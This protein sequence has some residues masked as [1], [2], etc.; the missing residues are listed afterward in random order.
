MKFGKFVQACAGAAM[1]MTL[2]AKSSS[3]EAEPPIDGLIVRLKVDTRQQALALRENATV[4]GTSERAAL[5]VQRDTNLR[6]RLE[7]LLSRAGAASIDATIA[8]P[9]GRA[10]HLLR[11]SAPLDRAAAEAL[12]ETLKKQPEIESVELNSVEPRLDAVVSRNQSARFGS[13]L[14]SDPLYLSQQWMQS[15]GIRARGLPDLPS[16][17][18][19]STGSPTGGQPFIAVAVLDTGMLGQHPDLAAKWLPG[20]DFISRPA[21]ANDGDGRDADPADPGDWVTA[22]DIAA[23]SALAGCSVEDSSW[24]G[25]MIA[26]EIAASTNNNVGVAG[27]NREARIVPVRVGGRCG[28]QLAD[29]IDGMRW[30]AGLAVLDPD[31]HAMPANPNP[32][33]VMNLS[34]GGSAACGAVFQDTIDELRTA[35]AV[36]V[37]AAGNSGGAVSRPANCTGVIG[38]GALNASGFKA[39]YSSFGPNLVISTVGGDQTGGDACSLALRDSGVLST[40]Y[41]GKQ[42]PGSGQ[43]DYA[44]LDGTSFAAPI[45]TGTVSL[46]LAINPGL[47]VEQIIAGLRTTARPHVSA[48]R[49]GDCSKANTGRCSCSTMSCGAGILDS[50]HALAFAADPENPVASSPLDVELVDDERLTACS[51]G[52]LLS[53]GGLTSMVAP[54]DTTGAAAGSTGGGVIDVVWL[55][56]LTSTVP[57]L[58][59]AR[60]YRNTLDE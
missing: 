39:P 41:S 1:A 42:E 54:T 17:W 16:A 28:A 52:G 31:G 47:S 43:Y 30:A 2:A 20:Y 24:H 53:S 14:P 51:P 25:T 57:A 27:V 44:A 49:L 58:L 19:R 8:Q 29:I 22:S 55:T 9:V 3:A 21:N 5:A 35:G 18:L 45:V 59:L 36:V 37:A 10:A 32:A 34:F 48:P 40:H 60:R 38:V 7:I 56:L 15:S 33:R 6:A 26:G 13:S 50:P 23:G 4:V 12:A 11:W 46:M